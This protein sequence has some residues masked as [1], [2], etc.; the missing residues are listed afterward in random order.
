MISKSDL[1][2]IRLPGLL[3]GM[4]QIRKLAPTIAATIATVMA[5]PFLLA[6]LSLLFQS[7]HK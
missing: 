5:M 1:G 6:K 4:N 2:V 7:L 3:W